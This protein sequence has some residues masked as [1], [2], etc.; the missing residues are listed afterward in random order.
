MAGRYK[1]GRKAVVVS[2]YREVYGHQLWREQAEKFM[3]GVSFGQRSSKGLTGASPHH[4]EYH[5]KITIGFL[6]REERG[7]QSE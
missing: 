4:P 1:A 7:S 2:P 6:Y 5:E 3:V